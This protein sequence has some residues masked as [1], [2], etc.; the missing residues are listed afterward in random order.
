MRCALSKSGS[1]SRCLRARRAASRLTEAGKALVETAAPALQDIAE[2]MDRIRAIKGRPAGL[3]RL[4]VPNIAAAA[5][6]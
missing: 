2:R 6:R 1:A 4:N 5:W 3:L